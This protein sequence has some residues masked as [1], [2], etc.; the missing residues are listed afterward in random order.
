MDMHT[1]FNLEQ[2]LLNAWPALQTEHMQG[3]VVRYALGHT[4]RAN[5]ATPLYPCALPFETLVQEVKTRYRRAQ[6]PPLFR[7]TPL[8]PTGLDDYLAQQGWTHFEETLTLALEIPKAL[9]LISVEEA[10]LT[11]E[12]TAS[13]NWVQGAA[14]AYGLEDW[15]EEALFYITQQIRLPAAFVTVYVDKKPVGFGL[16]VQEG[17]F[18]GLYD[19]AIA[20]AMRGKG[21]GGRLV[22]SLIH[23]GR[24]KGATQ[25]YLQVRETNHSARALYGKLGFQE[26]YRYHHRRFEG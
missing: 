6:L 14:K 13:P 23:W 16:G 18:V 10:I 19:L 1:V 15:Q 22:T 12:E 7:M 24:S 26:A 8:S 11:L 5:A 17:A 20:P 4:K 25:A 2:A 9:K 3:F 21:L